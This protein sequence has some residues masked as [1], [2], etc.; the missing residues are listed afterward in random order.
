LAAELARRIDGDLEPATAFLLGDLCHLTRPDHD[1]V[2]RVENA[3]DL[4]V[5]HVLAR[6]GACERRDHEQGEQCAVR[7]S[8][9][10]PLFPLP[11]RAR[12]RS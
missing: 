5:V 8:H 6:G 1:G 9:V 10:I 7:V 11:D 3:G 12:Q 2:L 4:E